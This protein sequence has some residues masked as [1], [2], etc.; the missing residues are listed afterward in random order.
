MY[1]RCDGYFAVVW[2]RLTR[3]TWQTCLLA[4]RQL[5]VLRTPFLLKEN[6]GCTGGSRGLH[7]R[8]PCFLC[9]VHMYYCFTHLAYLFISNLTAPNAVDSVPFQGKA[10]DV[11]L[12][13]NSGRL[14]LTHTQRLNRLCIIVLLYY[15]L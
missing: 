9:S 11:F 12:L 4:N 14:S 5:R 8:V 13:L 7:L 3:I 6:Y 1:S 15:F 10:Q 2:L